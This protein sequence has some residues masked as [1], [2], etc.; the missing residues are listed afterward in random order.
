MRKT[1]SLIL[2]VFTSTVLHNYLI[3]QDNKIQIGF[4]NLE[5]LFDTLDDKYTDDSEFLPTGRTNWNSEKFTKKIEH[6]ASVIHNMSSAEEINGTT[7]LG[8]CEAENSY[9]L[10]QLI[11]NKLLDNLG[12][13]IIHTNSPDKRGIDVA[14]LYQEKHFKV[15][16]FQSHTLFLIDPITSERIFTRDQLVVSGKLHGESTSFIVNHW[17]SRRGGKVNSE[18]KRL[19][20]AQLTRHILDSLSAVDSLQNIFIMGDFNDDPINLSIVEQL[21]AHC[22]MDSIKSDELY[23]PMCNLFKQGQGTL[24]YRDVW[25]LFDQIIVNGNLI[26]N[27]TTFT[28]IEAKVFSP[29]YLRQQEGR[30][31]NYPL[32][33]LAGSKYLGGFSDHFPVYLMLEI[34]Q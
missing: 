31:K 19:A 13:N 34:K 10:E 24:C 9:V 17:P 16:H 26:N 1:Y 23:N 2:L 6:L 14:L 33:T 29:D 27:S 25:N 11:R 5:N 20:A 32:R 30:Y 18:P 21:S 15:N 22:T 12:Y 3:A 8:V 7:I 28:F 4:Y